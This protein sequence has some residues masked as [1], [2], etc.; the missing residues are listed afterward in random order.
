MLSASTG[1]IRP[2]MTRVL[3]HLD[4]TIDD[5]K[6]AGVEIIDHTGQPMSDIGVVSITRDRV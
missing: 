1:E 4:R 3:R 6:D 2:E 5:L